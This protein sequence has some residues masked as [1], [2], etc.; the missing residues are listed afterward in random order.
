MPFDIINTT[1]ASE[2]VDDGTFT[3]AFPTGRSAGSY[4]G[5]YAHKLYVNQTVFSAPADFTLAFTTV[6]TVTWKAD[7]TL[8][9]GTEVALQVDI[10]GSDDIDA[11]V[12]AAGLVAAPVYRIDLGSPITLD[13]DGI[14]D[15]VAVDDAGPYTYTSADFKAGFDGTLDVPRALT[16]VGTT[17]AVSVITVTGTDV[18]GDAVVESLTLTEATPVVGKKAFKTVTSIAVAVGLSGDTFDLGW[19]DVLGLPVFLPDAAYV[20]AELED[21]AAATPGVFIAGVTTAATATTG[22]VRGTYVA[23]SATDGALAFSV[24]VALPDPVGQGVPQYAG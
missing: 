8:E 4:A 13:A 10:L 14:L 6:I 18:N 9:A 11:A 12:P 24:L 23:D 1:L 7:T 2:V 21:G 19:G 17:G 20:L 3:V 5:A 16:A 22:D 15:G